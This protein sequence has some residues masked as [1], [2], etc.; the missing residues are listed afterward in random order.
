MTH[1]SQT[2]CLFQ[3]FV[4]LVETQFP[5]KVQSLRTDNGPEF[6]MSEFFASKGILHQCSCVESPQQ[7]AVVERKHQHLLNVACS[8]RFQTHLPLFFGGECILTAAH[9]IN[10]I[11]TPSLSNKSPFEILYQKPP[12]YSHLRVF[13]SLCYASTLTRSRSKFD[14]R[15]KPCLFLGYPSGVKGYTLFDLHTKSIFIS[16]DVTFHESIFPYAS[17][18]LHPTSDGCFVFPLSFPDTTCTYP[19]TQPV[20]RSSSS[21]P[22]ISHSPP[23]SS[24]SSQP[25]TIP[26]RRST[27][28]KHPPSYLTN[29]HCQVATSPPSLPPIPLADSAPSSGIKYPLSSVLSYHKLS[30]NHLRFSMSVS[31]AF[32]PQFYH[33]A[34]KHLHWRAAMQ[35]EIAAL[36]ENHT[37]ILV[38]LP[39]NKKPIGCKWVYR[40]KYKSDGQIE[41]YKARL[42]AKGYTQCEGLDYHETF[43]PV[44]KLTTVRLLFALA[45]A[46]HWCLHQLDVN[47][48]FLHGTL[49][50]EVYLQLPPGF[51]AKGG[52]QGL[53]AYQVLIRFKTGLS[54]M[55]LSVLHDTNS[56]WFCTIQ[57]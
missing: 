46:N 43:S 11:P 52:V 16:R 34:V 32:E 39:P 12:T 54:A 36:E 24:N 44:A 29:F 17:H 8:L 30:N 45:A 18:L 48:A 7:N 31:S 22:H 28:V 53:Q 27:R 47:N 40:V 2:R 13:G 1:K 21:S 41:R 26:L 33:Q 56:S 50:E 23:I 15:A 55:V 42:V 35:A 49:D 10:R 19:P 51:A 3:S 37:W 38:D 14:S 9:I 57:S 5:Y 4:N 6:L 25:P 20:P